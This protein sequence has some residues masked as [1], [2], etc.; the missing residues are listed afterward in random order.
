[1]N[2]LKATPE[3]QVLSPVQSNI[4]R[5]ILGSYVHLDV[6]A[7]SVKEELFTSILNKLTLTF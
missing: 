3:L 4:I 7:V 6:L 2:G 5:K 1:M